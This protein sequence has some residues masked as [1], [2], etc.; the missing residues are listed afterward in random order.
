MSDS[1]NK[2]NKGVTYAPQA[3]APSNPTNGDIYYNTT[4]G[5]QFRQAGAWVSLSF[6][7]I[8][9]NGNSFGT[10]MTIGTNDANTLNFETNNVIKGAV[11]SA[12]AWTLGASGGTETHSINGGI[13][14]TR[15]SSIGAAID[16]D[17]RLNIAGTNSSTSTSQYGVISN[18]IASSTATTLEGIRG[19][20]RIGASHALSNAFSFRAGQITLGSGAT[21]TR[22]TGYGFANAF[23]GNATNTC[24]MG[25]NNTYLG[26]WV[27]N[28]TSTNPSL[29]SGPQEW[30]QQTTPSNPA[31][32]NTRIY[33]KS[34][35]KLYKLVSGGTET[36][37]GGASGM[38]NP[39][40]TTGDIIYSSDNSGTPARLGIGLTGATLQVVAGIPAWVGGTNYAD[41]G[42]FAGGF[43]GGANTNVMD[44]VAIATTGN[45]TD[46]GDL[47]EGKRGFAGCGSSTRGVFAGGE[48]N[49]S[50]WYYNDAIEY[51]TIA[52]TG[53]ATSFGT[54]TLGRTE[55]SGFS[56]NTTGIWAG[57]YNNVN[58]IDYVTIA[59]VG[60]ATD[61]GDLTVARMYLAA[62]AS[63]TR[64]LI[65]GG[66]PNYNTIDYVTIASAGNATDFGDLT[67][68]RWGLGSCSSN[69]R[70]C[71]IGGLD[72]STIASN[73]IDYVTIASAGNA[74][75]FGDITTAA[76]Y[77]TATSNGVR[78]V[79]G[80]G[81][82]SVNTIEYITIASA[83]NA[84][85]F[86]NLTVDR[87][88]LAST[89]GSHGGI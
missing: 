79:I 83:G 65:G 66:N 77:L 19:N 2:V 67:L 20:K 76:Y 53:N 38:A 11:S 87:W 74:T 84:T 80:S 57:G 41:R 4:L 49:S 8:T 85:D 30:K 6:G 3:S 14:T 50:P 7:D 52:T 58:T 70:G 55:I 29:F 15:N 28:F 22:D 5:W 71:W 27:F 9:N 64:G 32:G 86:G 34:D 82:T 54:L 16:A 48:Q 89:S 40:T 60:N 18:I 42:I 59:S 13:S 44:Y 75:D 61:F 1:F 73:I 10:A 88:G 69:T 26:N 17:A 36:E 78:G 45:A 72:S 63:P 51:I 23:A 43:D 24:L 35:D 25:D 37:I 62:C 31:S 39:M 81:L 47:T 68:A 21:C 12:G 46:F 56:D 33:F